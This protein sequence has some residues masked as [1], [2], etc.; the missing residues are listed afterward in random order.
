MPGQRLQ[1]TSPVTDMS[2]EI[3]GQTASKTEQYGLLYGIM[4]DMYTGLIDFSEISAPPLV[5]RSRT[6]PSNS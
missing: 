5:P 3:D 4:K 6:P 1:R 2:D